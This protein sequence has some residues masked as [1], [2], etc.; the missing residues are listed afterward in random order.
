MVSH[1]RTNEGVVFDG[2]TF[3]GQEKN[4]GEPV[5]E[6]SL[7]VMCMVL[8]LGLDKYGLDGS[9]RVL[10]LSLRVYR[11]L[12]LRFVCLC[13]GNLVVF[14]VRGRASGRD[15]SSHKVDFASEERVVGLSHYLHSS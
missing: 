12:Y 1:F 15:F 8:N 11:G 5:K 9:P 14:E 10:C 13:L 6:V 2:D 4:G 3:D 7:L